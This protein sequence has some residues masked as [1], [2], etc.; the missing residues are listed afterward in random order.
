MPEVPATLDT[1]LT[2][3]WFLLGGMGVLFGLFAWV[4]IDMQTGRRRIYEKVDGA[5]DKIR[6]E[7]KAQGDAQAAALRSH[8]EGCNKRAEDDARW[9]GRIEGQLG[10]DKED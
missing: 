8:E 4:A 3:E 2:V 1:V 9:K 7:I 10:L 5:V 6:I